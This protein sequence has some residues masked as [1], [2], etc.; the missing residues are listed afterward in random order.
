MQFEIASPSKPLETSHNCLISSY[1]LQKI[2]LKCRIGIPIGH[3][4]YDGV[5]GI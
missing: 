1:D 3:I 4:E 2:R 5:L